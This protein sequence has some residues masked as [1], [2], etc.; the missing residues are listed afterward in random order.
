MVDVPQRSA[1]GAGLTE[2]ILAG[3]SSAEDQLVL[4]FGSRIHAFALARVHNSDVAQDLV[5]DTLIAV[6][7]ALRT[8]QLN[9][10]EKL[11]A[12]VLGT[13]RNIVNSYLR[14]P[15]PSQL[16]MENLGAPETA[17][18]DWQAAQA[19][20]YSQVQRALKHLPETDQQI[21]A[22]TLS[23]GLKSGE[24]AVRLGLTSEVVRQRKSRA[25]KKIRDRIRSMSRIRD[26]SDIDDR[27]RS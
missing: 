20:R 8:G 24:I 12:Y 4:E 3:D 13:A 26:S 5:H 1:A 6:L 18:P 22:L 7:Q 10:S 23:A 17:W 2:R 14:R 21:L 16:E 15:K 27:E 19:Q 11:A 9:E 25:I